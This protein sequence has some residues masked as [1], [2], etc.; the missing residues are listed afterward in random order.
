M[1]PRQSG[2]LL[3]WF[4]ANSV[5][6]NLLML[7]IAAGGLLSAWDM[8]KQAYPRFAS[9]AIQISPEYPAAGPSEVEESVCIP[10]EEA[11]HD[12]DG[13]KRLNSEAIEG[14]CK[15]VVQVLQDYPIRDLT[16]ALRSRVQALKHL[17]KA[18]EHIDIDDSGWEYPAISVVL[19]GTATK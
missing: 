3:A 7:L 5:A 12:L 9:E 19:Y 15:I 13:I 14:E 16:N 10:I 4:A 11:I 17:P 2:S 1:K 18:V 8:V 6:A